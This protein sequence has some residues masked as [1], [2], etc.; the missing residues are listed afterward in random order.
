MTK[1]ELQNLLQQ[2]YDQYNFAA[3]VLKNIFGNHFELYAMPQSVSPAPTTG[4]K[5][6]IDTVKRY[7][8]ITLDDGSNIACYEVKLQPQVRIEQSRV[9]IQQYIR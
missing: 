6:T 9:A 5:K 1:I 3:K 4:E 7:G 2:P 8:E